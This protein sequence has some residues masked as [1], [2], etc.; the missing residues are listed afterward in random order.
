MG[1]ILASMFKRFW[2]IFGDRL[3][4]KIDKKSIHKG[5]EKTMQK[6]RATRWPKSRYKTLRPIATPSAQRPGE[7]PIL[8][9]RV[10]PSPPSGP[11][12]RRPYRTRSDLLWPDLTWSDLIWS[13]LI[14]SDLIGSDLIWSDFLAQL[15]DQNPSKSIENRCQDAFSCWFH[16]MI[17][18]WSKFVT[19]DPPESLKLYK[20]YL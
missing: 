9:W 5:I 6:R 3:G 17:D 1:C 15:G 18:F 13:D 14:W 8:S 16:F 11:G 19:P 12:R 2:W 20:D 4:G 10:N 7:G